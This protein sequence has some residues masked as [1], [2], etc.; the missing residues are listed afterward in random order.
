M[1]AR[2]DILF[3]NMYKRSLGNEHLMT[4]GFAKIEFQTD[5]VVFSCNAAKILVGL[6]G[7]KCM[8]GVSL[9][10]KNRGSPIGRR[11]TPKNA[12]K[13]GVPSFSTIYS[14]YPKCLENTEGLQR[15]LFTMK[16]ESA[17]EMV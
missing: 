17:N 10:S 5:I 2:K 4:A 11:R 14:S 3:H 8:D 7:T 16:K 13:N 1:V 6:L 12:E 15:S 9:P